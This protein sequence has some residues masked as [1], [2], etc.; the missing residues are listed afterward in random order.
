MRRGNKVILLVFILLAIV[1][2]DE[3]IFG[4]RSL[5]GTWRVTEESDAFG[6]QNFLVGI[7]YFPGDSSR[8]IIDNFSNL[9]LG[10]EVT[11]NVSSLNITIPQQTVRDVNL[12]SYR[13]SG[14]GNAT[15]NL[16]RINWS[17]VID[18]DDYT[19][20]FEKQ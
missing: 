18:T 17:Y 15:S 8:V 4:P 19:A 12:N 20:V 16:R 14:N 11:A 7:E 6:P 9:G 13:I 10:F 5:E 2:C 3:E 1:S